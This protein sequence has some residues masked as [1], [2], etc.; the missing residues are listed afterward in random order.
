[1]IN[2]AAVA[3]QRLLPLPGSSSPDKFTEQRV[4][5]DTACKS[6]HATPTV[7]QHQT[8]AVIRGHFAVNELRA[9]AHAAYY[10]HHQSIKRA[11]KH[12][13]RSLR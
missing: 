10:T 11:I 5:I 4:F 6:C 7:S 3:W 12:P 2:S 9:H 8:A 13:P 1:M